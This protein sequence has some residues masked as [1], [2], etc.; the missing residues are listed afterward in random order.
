MRRYVLFCSGELSRAAL[1]VMVF[2]GAQALAGTDDLPSAL[3]ESEGVIADSDAALEEARQAKVREAEHHKIHDETKAQAR[4]AILSAK[5]AE[6]QAR[7]D[8]RAAEKESKALAKETDQFKKETIAS[9]AKKKK[10]LAQVEKEK[11]KLAKLQA[12]RD[13]AHE[14]NENA[15]KENQELEQQIAAVNDQSEQTKASLLQAENEGRELKGRV[16]ALKLEL[17]KAEKAHEKMAAASRAT[18][19]VLAKEKAAAER[20]IARLEA[21]KS[22]QEKTTED[23]RQKLEL[24]QGE[25]Q[26]T[27]ERR[28]EATNSLAQDR[29]TYDELRKTYDTNAD[30]NAKAKS[31]LQSDL[32][33]IKAEQTR[34]R[35]AIKQLSQNKQQK[36]SETAHLEEQVAAAREQLENL[37]SD[38]K[39]TKTAALLRGPAHQ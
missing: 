17:A 36:E 18:M 15:K 34:I 5:A 33:K 38:L 21:Q 35:Q 4:E 7:D 8:I 14:Q 37:R 22:A 19:K 2:A 39:R 3:V 27:N 30:Q 11:A 26:L 6:S 31:K 16:K 28:Q 24:V 32:G 9:E 12:R 10:L 13:Q 20:D 1:A 25:T 29:R 23:L